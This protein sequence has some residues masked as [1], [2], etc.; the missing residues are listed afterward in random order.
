MSRDRLTQ[1]VALVVMAA[2]LFAS[3]GVGLLL[4]ASAGRHKLVYTDV[5]EKGQPPQVALGIAMGAFRGVF[6][7]FLWI[8]ANH[9]KE[10]GKYHEAIELARAITKLQPRF[11]RVWVFHAW[12]MAYNISV[13]TQ[14]PDERWNWV[15]AGINLLRDEGVP[16]NTSDTLIH[17]ELAWIFLHKIQ[18]YTDDVNKYYKSQLAAEWQV[19]VGEPPRVDPKNRNRDVVV[20]Q[21]ADWLRGFN[22]AASTMEELREKNPAAAA[23]GDE[24]KALWPEQSGFAML[25]LYELDRALVRSPIRPAIEKQMGPKNV[26]FLQMVADPKRKDAW[27][28]LTRYV[29]KRL[30][31]LEYHM[32]IPKM[33]QYTEKFGPLDWRHPASHGLYWS[34][35]GVER[36]LRRYNTANRLD[37]DFLNTD[38]V[39][40][41]SIQELWRS[42]EVYFDFMA[43]SNKKDGTYLAIPNAYFAESYGDYV[44]ELMDRSWA[45]NTKTRIYTSYGSGYE[46]FL[47]DVVRFFYRR[48][49]LDVAERFYERLRTYERRNLNDPTIGITLYSLPMDEF[50]ESELKDR[51]TSP[52]V[53]LQE[54]TASLMDGFQ[55]GL[56]GEDGEAYRR[57]VEYAKRFHRYYMEKQHRKL[58]TGTVRTEKFP[59]DFNEVA[60]VTF[61]Q[62]LEV[63]P[64]EDIERVYRSVDEELQRWAYDKIYASHS[65]DY[66]VIE[67]AGGKSFAVAFPEPP[68]L[69]EFRARRQAEMDKRAVEREG[70]KQK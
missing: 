53:A 55:K 12:N 26:V 17:K 41:H 22:E 2:C 29:R 64:A 15:N 4:T 8:R 66:K 46:N 9:L 7:N 68:G 5:A 61:M 60:G 62:F 33:I 58:A 25:R 31:T 30:L 65:E 49:Q 1:I 63:V 47:K 43:A 13:T 11:P 36:G 28:A 54:I 35:L 19:V 14:T 18:G 57:C 69:A 38:R 45:D 67:Q 37:F 10:E 50:V 32:E 39:A 44:G 59:T 34:T 3:G 20:K 42:G 52:D 23:L 40:I 70:V 24:I 51:E 21:Y 56:L 6:V 27:E 16:A 48:G